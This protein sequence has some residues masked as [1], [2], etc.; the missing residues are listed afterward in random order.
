MCNLS[1]GIEERTVEKLILSMY[2]N[3]IS[4]EQ[5]SL[6]TK[7]NKEEIEKIINKNE[8]VLA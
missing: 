3:E 5:I 6:I 4:L 7:K 1:D 2:E 8:P